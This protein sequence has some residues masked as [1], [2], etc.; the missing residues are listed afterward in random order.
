MVFWRLSASH[1]L[2]WGKMIT[3]LLFPG[4]LSCLSG[5]IPY[6]KNT[7]RCTGPIPESCATA[8]MLRK[9]TRP[10]RP[11]AGLSAA[12][13]RLRGITAMLSQGISTQQSDSQECHPVTSAIA[14]DSTYGGQTAFASFNSILL[15]Q[16]RPC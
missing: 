16:H 2:D 14:H 5:H 6:I 4:V 7:N 13:L 11:S 1:P 12:F 10:H 15:V 3:I 9:Q 8:G